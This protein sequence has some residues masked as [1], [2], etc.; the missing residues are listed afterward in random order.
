[1]QEVEPIDP[2]G[3]AFIRWC[4]RKH[5]SFIRF[6]ELL[7]ESI[8]CNKLTNGG[9]LQRKLS[10]ILKAFTG[11]K[12]AILPACSGT[13]ALH[14]L[15]AAHSIKSK[16]KL[17]WATQAFTFP[18]SIQGILSESIVVD[19]DPETF[20]ISLACLDIIR[21]EIDGVIVTNLFGTMSTNLTDVVRWCRSNGKLIVFDNAATPVGFVHS[22]SLH[23][24]SDGSIIS[25]HE[26]KPLGRGEG[27]ALIV[28]ES[29]YAFVYEAMNFGFQNDPA[30]GV[31]RVGN[32]YG[33]NFRCSDIAA[34]AIISH[35]ENIQKQKWIDTIKRLKKHSIDLM[36]K[37]GYS[38]IGEPT[39]FLPCL[40]VRIEGLERLNM[41]DV[42]HQLTLGS[43][44]IEAK[45]YYRPLGSQKHCPQAWALFN[46][47]IC[48]PLHVDMS[49][50]Q[51]TLMFQKL[52]SILG[53][54]SIESR[55]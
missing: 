37:Y 21:E 46:S 16:R 14:C 23:D 50:D 36:G 43:L 31:C 39:D 49:E 27:G 33:S 54:L 55:I 52:H 15:C 22:S 8:S 47:T 42:L 30:G 10:D 18:P 40:P 12:C 32:R 44:C 4:P 17:T 24:L 2:S 41:S 51:V 38:L 20:G 19:M 3:K 6:Q 25:L 34:A 9:P 48:L 45:Q 11:S 26:T 35:I 28:P 5:F 29:L 13:G 7:K 1:M 53:H